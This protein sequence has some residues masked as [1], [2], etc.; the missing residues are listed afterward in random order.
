MKAKAA[1]SEAQPGA[2]PEPNPKLNPELSSHVLARVVTKATHQIRVARDMSTR[3]IGCQSHA[4]MGA[5]Q[6]NYTSPCKH[7]IF[8]K[9]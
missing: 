5:N 9:K 6:P 8:I 2:E 1:N 4:N 3:M 7:I